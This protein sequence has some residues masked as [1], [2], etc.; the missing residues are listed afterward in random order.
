MQR[1]ERRDV[2]VIHGRDKQI[3]RSVF[4]FVRALDLNPLEWEE[5]IARAVNQT[6]SNMETITNS[7]GSAGAVLSVF[8]PDDFTCLR[9]NLVE[10]DEEKI[11]QGQ[12]RPN[13][14]FET[15]LARALQPTRTIIAHVGK[16]RRITDLE[17]LNVVMLD[18]SALAR[19]RLKSRLETLCGRGARGNRWLEV[20][21]FSVPDHPEL[22]IDIVD[23][24]GEM[25]TKNPRG[26]TMLE[27]INDVGLTDVENRDK[28]QKSLAP[29]KVYDAATSEIAISGISCLLTFENHSE[30]IDG[31]LRAG[32]RIYVLMVDPAQKDIV[33]Q[34][35]QNNSKDIGADIASTIAAIKANN[36]HRHHNFVIRFLAFIPPFTGVLL[37]GDIGAADRPP[38]DSHAIMRVQP[39]SRFKSQHKG[40][41]LQLKKVPSGALDYFA[42]DLRKQWKTAVERPELFQ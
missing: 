41:V 3:V 1:A 6:P 23:R 32:R 26:T 17:G 24:I 31:H 38:S 40:V 21:D 42:G 25:N 14:L 30:I 39:S 9:S 28:S 13:V 2:F 16:I 18:N 10:V 36:F 35:S 5:L 22:S 33:S 27:A 29:D 20:G 7:L 12:P 8:T 4:D 15:G 37:D 19:N 11:F 34:L